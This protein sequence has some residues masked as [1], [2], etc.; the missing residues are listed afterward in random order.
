[1]SFKKETTTLKFNIHLHIVQRYFW[2]ASLMCFI[3]NNNKSNNRRQQRR[4]KKL[5]MWYTYWCSLF[6]T[7][8]ALSAI[9]P[10]SVRFIKRFTIFVNKHNISSSSKLIKSSVFQSTNFY[11]VNEISAKALLTVQLV[12]AYSF[13]KRQRE[14][15]TTTT[16]TN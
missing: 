16:K 8:T 10:T 2:D 14:K 15:T 7:H 6:T 13:M 5:R 4:R 11:E 12:I 3:D 9:F 1:M